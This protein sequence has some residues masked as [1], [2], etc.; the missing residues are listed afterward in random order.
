MSGIRVRLG[1][2]GRTELV[3]LPGPDVII[4]SDPGCDLV[5]DHRSVASQHARLLLRRGRLILAD[6]GQSP[7]G[8]T[9]GPDRLHAPVTLG[10]GQRVG[11]G[12]LS[13][14]VWVGPTLSLGL[15]TEVDCP[16]PG[17]RRF[18]TRVEGQYGELLAL[19]PGVDPGPWSAR[20]RASATGLGEHLFEPLPPGLRL[21]R[22]LLALAEG[23]V[24][25]PA[26]AYLMLAVGILSAYG[27]LHRHF[28][29]HG[30]IDPRRIQL[31]LDGAVR[32][33]LPGPVDHFRDPAQG[34][35][36]APERRYGLPKSHA[37]DVYAL[38][39]VLQTLRESG[40]ELPGWASWGPELL[41]EAPE[42]RPLDLDPAV[43]Q[44]RTGA[45]A[46]GWDPAA[47]HLARAVRLVE[48]EPERRFSY[49]GAARAA[50]RIRAQ[51]R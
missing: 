16:D 46:Q 33:V 17:L 41:A 27:P 35:F 28:G 48:P 38:G 8:V 1:W 50:L 14:E 3:S 31:G 39:A 36:L 12:D 19:E 24:A 29:A 4:G 20:A 10:P 13:V 32:V 25:L 5:L 15:D 37:A 49:V 21:D 40:A 23:R 22:L 44:L 30:L 42:D 47:H 34:P 7:T 43:E 45:H 26:E 11:L 6:L 9:R 51:A 2:R 18:A